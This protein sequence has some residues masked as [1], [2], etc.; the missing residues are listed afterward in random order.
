MPANVLQAVLVPA[1]SIVKST[2]V[3]RDAK[4]AGSA[5]IRPNCCYVL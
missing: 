1:V 2:N 5:N 4:I 3:R